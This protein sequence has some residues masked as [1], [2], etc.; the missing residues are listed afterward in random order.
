MK[1]NKEYLNN[2]NATKNPKIFNV[3]LRRN[4]EGS[5]EALGNNTLMLK[6]QLNEEPKWVRVDTRDFVDMLNKHTIVAK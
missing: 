5:L 2:R 4:K 6:K 3:T 1:R